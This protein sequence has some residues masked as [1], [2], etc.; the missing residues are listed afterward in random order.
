MTRSTLLAPLL[1]GLQTACSFD[2]SGTP[3]LSSSDTTADDTPSIGP[4]PTTGP[5][6]PTSTTGDPLP[7]DSTTALPDATTTTGADETS[8]AEPSCG[9]GV[10]GGDEECDEGLLS[11]NNTGTCTIDCQHPRCG[12]GFVQPAAGET[13]D[14]GELNAPDPGYNQ[15]GSLTCTLG[16]HCGDGIVQPSEECE[17]DPMRGEQDTCASNCLTQTRTL[18]LSSITHSGDFGGPYAADA[19]CD[20]LAAAAALPGTYRAWLLVAG[21]T[22]A[23]RFST[24]ADPALAYTFVSTAG[25]PL[26]NNFAELVAYGPAYAPYFDEHGEPHPDVLVWTGITAGGEAAADCGEWKTTE[27]VGLVGHSGFGMAGPELQQWH[28][29]RWWTD[30]SGTHMFCYEAT[31]HFYCLQVTE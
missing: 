17:P 20:Q 29:E 18:F 15:C 14:D 6:S 7:D 11:N 1:A 24:L 22:L 8:P 25:A 31:H 12:D 26:A 19:L 9:D 23:E 13:C 5:N 10:I 28:D 21:K 3:T 16:P 27:S 30:L 2:A 4:P